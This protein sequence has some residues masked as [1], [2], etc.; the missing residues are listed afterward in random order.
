MYRS[1]NKGQKYYKIKLSSVRTSVQFG[2]PRCQQ[3][4]VAPE[5]S[6]RF[7]LLGKWGSNSC[8]STPHQPCSQ[9]CNHRTDS[10]LLAPERPSHSSTTVLQARPGRSSTSRRHP[11]RWCTSY[12]GCGACRR[13]CY[14]HSSVIL[15]NLY[16]K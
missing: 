8:D 2:P 7:K 6:F 13:R 4:E 12:T 14:Q 15:N 3:L 9:N 16:V 11:T 10:K 1:R 5:A